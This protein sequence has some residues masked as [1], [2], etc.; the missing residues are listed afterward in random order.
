[1]S[2]RKAITLVE[3]LVVIAI[4]AVLMALTVPAV[5]RARDAALRIESTNNLRQMVLAVQDFATAHEDR[6]PSIDGKAGGPNPQTSVHWAILP[7]IDQGNAYNQAIG[8]PGGFVLVKTYLSPADPTAQDAIAHREEVSSY[9][10]NACAFQGIPRLP[11][12]L[13]DGTSNTI[14]FAE[15]YSFRCQGTSF[16][17]FMIYTGV[18]SAYHR[19]SFADPGFDILPVTSP[20]PPPPTSRPSAPG[21]T[22]QVAP[23]RSNCAPFLAQTPHSGGMLSAMMDGS[24]RILARGM[25]ETTYW[26]AVT[27][28]GGE[29]FGNDW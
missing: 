15:H 13:P 24:V 28:A 22:F 19:A 12:S 9:A 8:N 5:M 11:S 4:I 16:E 27:P 20:N 18:G 3:V 26:A 21:Y 2:H 25:S 1:M 7:Y 29:V 17:S 6:L 23:L 14:A 10:A